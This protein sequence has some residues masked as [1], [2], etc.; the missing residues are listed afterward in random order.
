MTSL[1]WARFFGRRFIGSIRGFVTMTNMVSIAGSPL[2][3]AAIFEA[4]G[5]YRPAFIILLAAF[6]ASA[7]FILVSRS[8]EA[9]FQR[10]KCSISFTAKTTSHGGR[11][12]PV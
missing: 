5:T 4:T 11:P 9:S 10:I 3:V 1:L 8:P 7:V 2:L 12:L 6:L